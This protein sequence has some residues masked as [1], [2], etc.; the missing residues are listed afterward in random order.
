[1]ISTNKENWKGKRFIFLVA[2]FVLLLACEKKSG[3][4]T[5]WVNS[6]K[7]DCIGVGPMQCFQIKNNEDEPW[8][9]LYQEISGFDFEPGYI[10]KLSVAIDTLDQANLPADKPYLEYRLIEVLSKQTDP[11][12]S[13]NDIWV[14]TEIHGLKDDSMISACLPNLELN[15]RTMSFLGSDGCNRNRGKIETLSGNEI[16]FG[17]V[18][19]TKKSCPDMSIPNNYASA[20]SQVRQFKREGT[21]LVFYD[22]KDSKLLTFKKLD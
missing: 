18:M 16:K 10:Y 6:A 7:T 11:F 1:M 19:S 15:T 13:L 2:V 20:L 17:P 9:N 5:I 22:V 8:T 21:E 3:A 14:V 4:K 12:L